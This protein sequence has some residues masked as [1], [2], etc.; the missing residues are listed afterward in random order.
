MCTCL[1]CVSGWVSVG[2]VEPWPSA[3]RVGEKNICSPQLLRHSVQRP[4]RGPFSLWEPAGGRAK[5]SRCVNVLELCVSRSLRWHDLPLGQDTGLVQYIAVERLHWWVFGCNV[6]AE[7][8]H[9]RRVTHRSHNSTED[10][11]NATRLAKPCAWISQDKAEYH[12]NLVP[13]Q[14]VHH[15][16]ILSDEW[17]PIWLFWVYCTLWTTAHRMPLEKEIAF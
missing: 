1:L 5:G 15:C 13:R 16:K 14:K 6:H 4:V 9:M 17:V 8:S 10:F 11:S 3:D 2:V 12:I 7:Q